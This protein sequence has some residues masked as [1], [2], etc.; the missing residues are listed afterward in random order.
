MLSIAQQ[1]PRLQKINIKS[2]SRVTDISTVALGENC[3]DL[4]YCNFHSVDELTDKTLTTFAANCPKLEHLDL[5][6]I[7]GITWTGIAALGRVEI[8]GGF[9]LHGC[10]AIQV[11]RMTEC[12][13]SEKQIRALASQLPFGKSAGQRKGITQVPIRHRVQNAYIWVRHTDEVSGLEV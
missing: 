4:L 6:N 13:V 10:P 2:C 11:V 12:Q 8:K 5:Q 7:H 1:C 9:V 3:P